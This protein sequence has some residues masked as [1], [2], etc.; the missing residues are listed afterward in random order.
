[1]NRDQLVETVLGAIVA[2]VAVGFLL[3]ALT[4]SG[5]GETGGGYELIAKFNR[6]DGISVGSDVRLAGVKVG[7]VSGVSLDTQTFQAKLDLAIDPKV[8]LP[9]DSAAKIMTDGLLGGA[10]VS[11]EPGGAEQVLNSGAEIADTQGSVDLLTT[12]TS[13][14]SG[15]SAN[16]SNPQSTAPAP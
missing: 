11:L 8:K 10:Y 13:A 4:Q 1:M 14:I 12:L 3:F 16:N 9:E 2:A 6:A 5:R 7:A 15:M